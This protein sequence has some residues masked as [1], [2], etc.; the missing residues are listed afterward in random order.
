MV[1]TCTNASFFLHLGTDLKLSVQVLELSKMGT[2]AKDL[3]GMMT[4]DSV[5]NLNLYSQ[6]KW[7]M[8]VIYR[9][10]ILSAFAIDDVN[11][12]SHEQLSGT[13]SCL[14]YKHVRQITNRTDFILS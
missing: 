6:N 3:T 2:M 10:F 9:Q 13:H 7:L 14:E 4:I 1:C 12:L 11:T 8:N 5:D